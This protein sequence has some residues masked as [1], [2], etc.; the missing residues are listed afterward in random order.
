[1][2]HK[3]KKEDGGLDDGGEQGGEFEKES[4]D[5]EEK[6]AEGEQNGEEGG[7]EE[8]VDYGPSQESF[9]TKIKKAEKGELVD[10]K[11][12]RGERHKDKGDQKIEDLAKERAANKDD[13]G[14]N[15]VPN[16]LT[17]D[18]EKIASIAQGVGVNIGQ[19]KYMIENN[20]SFI[21]V[22]EQ[23][24]VDLWIQNNANQNSTPIKEVRPLIETGEH[25]IEELI[26]DGEDSDSNE[27]GDDNWDHLKHLFSHRKGKNR[28]R[29]SQNS[30]G[31]TDVVIKG[32]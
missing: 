1:M 22:V 6:R 25:N 30:R 20:T 15:N 3:L 32:L 13:Y 24:R 10:N 28:G 31:K 21:K 19:N 4:E 12:R 9:E 11:G 26:G 18:S 8:L 27:D 7:N 16:V 23:V 14:E 17:S 2:G 29:S 5:W